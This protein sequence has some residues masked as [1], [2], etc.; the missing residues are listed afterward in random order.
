MLINIL[1]IKHDY[2]HRFNRPRIDLVLWILTSRVI[3]DAINRIN[4]IRGGDY[5]KGTASWRKAYKKQWKKLANREVEV[6]N[7]QKYHTNPAR[8]TCACDAFL[9]SRFLI[10]KHILYCY[11]PIKDP[12]AFFYSVQRQRISPFWVDQQLIL[13]PQYGSYLKTTDLDVE[14]ANSMDSESEIENE[15]LQDDQSSIAEEDIE[16][17]IDT[18]G[19]EAMMKS[20]MDIY[21]EQKASGNRKFIEKFITTNA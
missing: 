15:S 3:P 12:I 17:K 11:M 4:S 6:E 21:Y 9:E 2:L 8:W 13:L 7:I 19:F 5:R 16:P 10:C 18:E 14:E 20:V 1:G